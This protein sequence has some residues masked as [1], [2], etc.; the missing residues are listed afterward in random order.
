MEDE[1]NKLI[2]QVLTLRRAFGRA[3]RPAH[4][5]LAVD[6]TLPQVKVLYLLYS[7][8]RRSMRPLAEGL[9]VALPTLTPI[10]DRLVERGLV[11]R[12]TDP[13]DRR[14]VVCRLTPQGADTVERLQQVGRERFRAL[15]DALSLDELAAVAAGFAVL[16][17]AAERLGEREAPSPASTP[18]D[19]AHR[20][21]EAACAR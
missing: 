12:E 15:L 1:R 2:E 6:L 8:G 10:V 14:L 16:C 18:T 9:G 3:A 19:Q 5:W 17:R 13:Q 11:E 21:E 7:S 4:E 20:R